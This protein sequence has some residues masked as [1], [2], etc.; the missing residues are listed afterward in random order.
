MG[1]QEAVAVA[2]VLL[3]LEAG[4]FLMV[5]RHSFWMEFG[6]LLGKALLPW[7]LK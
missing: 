1:W 2:V 5:Q 4:A 7:A 3:G 6:M